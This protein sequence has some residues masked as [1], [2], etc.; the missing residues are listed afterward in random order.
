MAH[1][2]DGFTSQHDP[3]PNFGLGD[4]SVAETVR[5]EWSS[6]IVQELHNVPANQILS[7]TEPVRL[8]ATGR[9]AF[10]F[11]SWKGQ[12]FGVEASTDL[13]VWSSLGSVT[14]TSGLIQ[15]SDPEAL[16]FAARFYRVLPR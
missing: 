4:A 15:F 13:S 11:R 6:G 1:E 12:I 9:G 16:S 14:N 2:N 3:R 10:E 8:Q 5:I 7:V